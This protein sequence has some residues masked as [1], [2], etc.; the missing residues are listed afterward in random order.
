MTG[1]DLT[2]WDLTG[3][4]AMAGIAMAGWRLWAAGGGALVALI[5]LWWVWT[6][7]RRVRRRRRSAAVRSWAP[8]L[9]SRQLAAG[10]SV[11][12]RGNTTDALQLE[13]SEAGAAEVILLLHGGAG[14]GDAWGAGYDRLATQGVLVVPDLPGIGRSIG[15]AGGTAVDPG[16][17]SIA[18]GVRMLADCLRALGLD[19]RPTLVV[20][21][22]LGA[23]LALHFAAARVQRDPALVAAVVTV[24]PLLFDSTGDADEVV[25]GA[26]RV[27]AVQ[28]GLRGRRRR[29]SRW[30]RRWRAARASPEVPA[31]VA[32]RAAVRDRQ[33]YQTSVRALTEDGGWRSAL[34]TLAEHRVL[35]VVASGRADPLVRPDRIAELVRN[36][37]GMRSAWHP[38]AGHDLPLADPAWCV[39]VI[40]AA[41]DLS[42]RRVHR[43]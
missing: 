38:S 23:T 33:A 14:T 40:R 36:Y 27:A 21:H 16:S 24:G 35:V 37:R 7:L 11:R 31:A 19:D 1:S 34:R 4:I 18:A 20:G 26:R 32:R 42:T 9:G 5:G 6:A 3:R 12:I 28:A 22:S 41:A 29:T 25:R 8:P 17:G 2:G 43:R 39:A 10:L 30:P 15:M 13:G